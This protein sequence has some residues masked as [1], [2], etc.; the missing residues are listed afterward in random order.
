M[1]VILMLRD[2]LLDFYDRHTKIVQPL[3]RLLLCLMIFGT[4]NQSL[5]YNPQAKP[6]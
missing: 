5:G 1:K 3:L 2:R 6:W 4:I